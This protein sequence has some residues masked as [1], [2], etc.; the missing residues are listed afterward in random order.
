MAKNNYLDA[1]FNPDDEMG[2]K[3]FGVEG[4]NALKG[5]VSG[6]VDS[7]LNN[8]GAAYPYA[9]H[10]RR[11]SALYASLLRPNVAAGA[12][13]LGASWF[14][15]ATDF[16][17]SKT[18]SIG[19]DIAHNVANIAS[20]VP[21]VGDYVK[22]GRKVTNL[23]ADVLNAMGFGTKAEDTVKAAAIGG[24]TL[25][26]IGGGVAIWYFGFHKKKKRGRK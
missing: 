26:L 21:Y 14:D 19:S 6:F 22:G 11:A 23:A 8:P 17:S 16:L 5:A 4:W 10:D 12:E 7:R 3:M 15:D 25:L 24:G 13:L 1:H 18:F 9:R 2:L 20:Y